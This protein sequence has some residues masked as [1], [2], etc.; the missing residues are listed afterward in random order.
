MF[1]ELK[2]EVIVRF[3]GIGIKM[4]NKNITLS[5]HLQNTIG[6]SEK[7]AKSI[8]LTHKYMTAHFPDLVY[9]YFLIALTFLAW[10]KHFNEK[11]AG[12]S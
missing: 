11:V 1:N 10:Y 5:E 12:F 2:W 3:V 6:R 9:I 4:E 7:K 8:H